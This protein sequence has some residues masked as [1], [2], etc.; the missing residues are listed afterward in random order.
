MPVEEPLPLD[1]AGFVLEGLAAP[2]LL[3]PPVVPPVVAPV[4]A[5]VVDPVE[6]PVVDPVDPPL[7]RQ[8]SLPVVTGKTPLVAGAP[9]LSL[10]DNR[11]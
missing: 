6:P 10:I 3:L 8:L 4:V 11:S 1:D 2:V 7:V 5:P 9:V